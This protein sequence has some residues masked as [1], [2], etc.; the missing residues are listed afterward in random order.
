MFVDPYDKARFQII[1]A[2][3]P[4]WALNDRGHRQEHFE[5]VYQCARFINERLELG[6]GEMNMLFAAY[7]HDLFAWSRVNHHQLAYEYFMGADHPVIVEHFGNERGRAAGNDRAGVAYAC[8]QHRASYKGAFVNQF[9]ELINSADRGFPG[10]AK[11]LFQRVLTHHTDINPDK[12]KDE[13]MAISL[14][15]I[16]DKA[17]TG[18]YAR[19]PELYLRVFGETLKEQQAAIDNL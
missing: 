18:G 13:V 16:K 9:A 1:T 5:S 19:Y 14:R 15:F 2:F 11:A 4:H 6:H 7:F 12:S 10:D 17:G 3:S 8:L